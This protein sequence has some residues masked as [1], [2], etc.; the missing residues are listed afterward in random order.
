[1]PG[2]EEA[3]ID[4]ATDFTEWLFWGEKSLFWIFHC[5]CIFTIFI[6]LLLDGKVHF[7]WPKFYREVLPLN[8]NF[9]NFLLGNE[10]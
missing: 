2:G 3:E 9:G 10:V 4:S 7:N 5:Q 8:T 1:M 6:T